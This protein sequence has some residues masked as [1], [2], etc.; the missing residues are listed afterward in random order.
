MNI[1]SRTRYVS[2]E[3]MREIDKCAQ[4]EFCIPALVLMENAGYKVYQVAQ[5][6]LSSAKRKR[7]VCV[8]GKGNNAGDGFVCV[9][10]LLN[11]GINTE[12]FLL[13]EPRELKGEARLNYRILE[14]MS[15]AIRV[16]KSDKDFL[17]LEHRAKKSSLLIDAI[18][19]I[20]LSGEVKEA[21]KKAI[22]IMNESGKPILAID[23]PSG[24]DANTGRILGLSIKA[25]KTVT[26]A[27][28]KIG[29]IRRDGPSCTGEVITVDI[30]IPKVLLK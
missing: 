24:L 18:F 17:L 14:R 6:M 21:Y 4:K 23:I 28:P 29:F 27:L 13:P 12:V 3:R 10:H 1:I 2:V 15:K 20:G 7:V 26:F 8:C 30:S 22:K 16:I 25:T 5:Q 11:A 9:R 19:G